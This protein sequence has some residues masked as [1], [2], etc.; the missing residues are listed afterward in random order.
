M[1]LP[2]A[3]LNRDA[4]MQDIGN[5]PAADSEGV[6]HDAVSCAESAAGKFQ[7]SLARITTT[8]EGGGQEDHPVN[9]GRDF[10]SSDSGELDAGLVRPSVAYWRLAKGIC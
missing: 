10:A 8:S 4:R 5:F 7:I 2:K 9:Q 6:G 1:L 3:G